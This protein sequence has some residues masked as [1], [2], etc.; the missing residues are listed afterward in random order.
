MTFSK[1]DAKALGL[2][3]FFLAVVVHDYHADA[4][5]LPEIKRDACTMT[6]HNG[7]VTKTYDVKGETISSRVGGLKGASLSFADALSDAKESVAIQGARNILP[8]CV[9]AAPKAR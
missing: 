5:P 6:Y 8:E 7:D 9:P 4:Q 2:S 1:S 3:A